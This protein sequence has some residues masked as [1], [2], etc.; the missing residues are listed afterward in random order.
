LPK[1][2][3][4][5]GEYYVARILK[6]LSKKNYKV[7]NNIYIKKNGKTSQIDHLVLS[8]YGIFVI[9]TKNYK[10][11]IFGNE[12]S[13]YWTQTLYKKKYAI[14]N[15]VIQNWTHVNFL[16][17]I[18]PEL[19]RLRYLP[20]VVFAGNAKLKKINSSTPVIRKRRLLRTIKRN[21]D[22]ILTH[23]QLAKI[24]GIIAQTIVTGKDVRKEHKKQV[25]K[26]I[27]RTKNKSNSSIC[28]KCGGRLLAKN[29]KFGNFQGCSNFPKCT[30]TKNIS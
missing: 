29:G 23:E 2:I 12:K 18:S 8:V 11:W 21:R 15:P 13:K 24:D 30:F 5:I 19:K 17:G 1:I 3:G 20:I 9:E 27:K 14:Y 26:N 25:K 28:P 6:R 16:K 4:S 10:G 7:Y 22:V